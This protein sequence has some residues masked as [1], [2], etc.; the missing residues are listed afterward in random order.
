MS[1]FAMLLRKLAVLPIRFYQY[2]ISPL[3][4]ARCRYYPTC[5][6]Y[7]HEA[8]MTHGIVKGGLLAIFRILRCN[9]W[10][11]GGHDPVPPAK[12]SRYQRKS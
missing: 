3:F 9:P 4:P 7:A 1:E 11:A 12:A 5:S 10:S 2:C 8:V 6:A